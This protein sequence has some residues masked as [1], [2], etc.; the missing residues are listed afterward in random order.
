M[1]AIPSQLF[2]CRDTFHAKK[3]RSRALREFVSKFRARTSSR[4][5]SKLQLPNEVPNFRRSTGGSLSF[6]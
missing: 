6:F 3:R 5:S 1:E 4:G 2:F